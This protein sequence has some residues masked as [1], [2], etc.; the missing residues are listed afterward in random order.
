[1]TKHSIRPIH[2]DARALTAPR[3]TI[4]TENTTSIT[5]LTQTYNILQHSKAKTHYI[6]QH[7]LHNNHFHRTHNAT[8]T[9]IKT[10]MRHI[11]TSIVCLTP[12]LSSSVYD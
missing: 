1:M 12:N 4:Q 8:T 2:D 9:D 11:Q 6:Q 10:N 3:V 5:P 7:S